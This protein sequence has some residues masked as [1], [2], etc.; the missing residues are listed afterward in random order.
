MRDA[1]PKTQKS[2]RL[3]GLDVA[4]YLAFVGMVVVNFKVVTGAVKAEGDVEAGLKAVAGALEGRA[5]A[6]FVILAGLGLGLASLKAR[7]QTVS[8]T[9][10]RSLFLLVVGLANTVIF[11][12]DIIHYYA[13]YYLFGVLLID[14]SD[15]QL[16]L[17]I[18]GLNLAAVVMM[19]A[20]NYDAEWD[21]TT[22][23][24]S[25]L[26]TFPGFLRNLFFNGWHPVVPWLGFLLYGVILSRTALSSGRVQVRLM[27]SGI[28]AVAIA[29][30]AHALLTPVL[31]GWD[32]ELGA[33]ATTSPIPPMPLYTL[34]GGG[35]ASVVIGGC[36]WI[37]DWAEGASVGKS[38]DKSL[39]IAGDK[40][41]D[42]VRHAVRWLV[43]NIVTPA[44]RQTLTL[45]IAH[46]LIGMGTLDALG[47]V[48]ENGL[49]SGSP[50]ATP[51]STVFL[52]SGLFLPYGD[53]V[54]RPLEPSVSAWAPRGPDAQVG[55]LRR[56]KWRPGGNDN[57]GQDGNS[58]SFLSV[59]IGAYGRRILATPRTN[60]AF[61]TGFGVLTRT[62]SQKGRPGG[63]T[64]MSS[65]NLPFLSSFCPLATMGRG[66]LAKGGSYALVGPP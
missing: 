58:R 61:I 28:L 16:I 12:A 44:G 63:K 8:V 10:R 42:K 27:V 1:N 24:Y 35:V 55:G 20:F 26:W 6:I 60:G 23:S 33:L 39:D 17:G 45:Y 37:A 36:L 9:L 65:C 18:V 40:S 53:R 14:R 41:G 30:A 49:Q 7:A 22:Y 66:C 5:A 59:L 43:R 32:A 38:M 15:R 31:S 50:A 13:V 11:E 56:G 51:L 48:E 57:G 52:A 21:W 46:I 29:E 47:L 62:Y 34:A 25:G 3:T 4:R 54:C 2:L 19:L 64:G